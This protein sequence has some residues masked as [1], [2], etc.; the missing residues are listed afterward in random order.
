MKY[1]PFFSFILILVFSACTIV[2]DESGPATLTQLEPTPIIGVDS[3]TPVLPTQES[4]KESTPMTQPA[5][6][7]SSSGL[8]VLIEKAREDLAQR[9]SIPVSQIDLVDAKDVVWPNASLGCP[10]P[11][12]AYAEVLT[13]GYLILLKANNIEY[14]YH[15]SRGTEVIYCENPIPP[16]SGTP[17]DQ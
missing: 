3:A 9:L 14:E 4:Q 11:G 12:M 10:R 5:Q 2:A 15:A 17:I 1:N 8:E 6:I 16:A 7:P 13:P